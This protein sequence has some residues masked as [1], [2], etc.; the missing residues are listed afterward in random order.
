[1]ILRESDFNLEALFKALHKVGAR[2][3]ILSESPTLEE[4]A[5]YIQK[6]WSSLSGEEY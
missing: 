3:R 6:T 5:Q 4:D 1:M 2:G